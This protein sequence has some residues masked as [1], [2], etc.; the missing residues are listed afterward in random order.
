LENKMSEKKNY[1]PVV[2]NKAI[3]STEDPVGLARPLL[4][5]YSRYQLRV[6]ADV[7]VANGVLG[8]AHRATIS[9]GYQDPWFATN[10]A[11]FDREDTYRT[12]YHVSYPDQPITR[13]VDNWY[14]VQPALDIWPRVIDLELHRNMP[15]D[16]IGEHTWNMSELVFTRDGVRPIIYTRYKLVE[17]W[18]RKWTDEMLQAHFWWFAQYSWLGYKEHPG[19]PTLPKRSDGS[20]MVPSRNVILHQTSDHK[21]A[22]PGEVASKAVDWNRWEQGDEADLHKFVQEKWGGGVIVPPDPPIDQVVPLERVQI[23]AGALNVRELPDANSKDLG[24]LLNGSVVPVVD[25][26]GAW[27]RIDGWIHGDWTNIVG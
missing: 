18:L 15:W 10:Y 20:V 4:R 16:A 19:P 17:Q 25:K 22:P 8:M 27:K 23:T 21:L 12:S 2:L 24:E 5:D 1:L 11:S 9:W 7:A 6:D 13:Q 14:A 26:K 3:Q